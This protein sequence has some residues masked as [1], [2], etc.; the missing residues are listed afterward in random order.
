MNSHI[1][2]M[3]VLIAALLFAVTVAMHE[4]V[5]ADSLLS[6]GVTPVADRLVNSVR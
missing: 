6:Q 1:S 4:A 2:L 3:G 5:R